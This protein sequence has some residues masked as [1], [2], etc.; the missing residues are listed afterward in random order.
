MMIWIRPK[1]HT[2]KRKKKRS[3]PGAANPSRCQAGNPRL[4]P[5]LNRREV[6]P[7][8]AFAV[9]PASLC[10]ENR[11][12]RGVP[13]HNVYLPAQLSPDFRAC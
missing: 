3:R 11:S 7:G 8:S 6:S 2:G 4:L 1:R 5:G 13:R 9:D 10:P 12:R